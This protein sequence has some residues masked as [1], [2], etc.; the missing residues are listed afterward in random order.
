MYQIASTRPELNGVILVLVQVYEGVLLEKKKR[1]CL[2]FASV[3]AVV[4]REM[5]HAFTV[6]QRQPLLHPFIRS[7]RTP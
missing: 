3:W 2:E 7:Q 4:T 1:T 6:V 5:D